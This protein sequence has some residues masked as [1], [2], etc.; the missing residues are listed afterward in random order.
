MGQQLAP[1]V[2]FLGPEEGDKNSAIAELR[3]AMAA[4][5]GDGL[6]EHTFYAFDTAI[7][8]VL[9]LLRNGSLFG[10][11]TIIR[12]RA[13]ESLKNKGDHEQLA[14]YVG[15]PSPDALLILETA[16]TRVADSLE[17]AVGKPNVRVF[18]EM[19]DNQKRGWLGGYFRRHKVSIEPDAVELILELVDNNTVDLQQEADRLI[20]WLGET[21]TVEDV[22]RYIYHVREESVFTL[23]DAIVA[24]DLDHALDIARA[25]L[26]TS[27]A[28][29]VLLGLSWQIDRLVAFQMIRAE[30]AADADLFT[31]VQRHLGGPPIRNR[32]AQESLRA[33]ARRY[34]YDACLRI[35]ALT[36][37]TDA[38]L[39]TVPS[40]LHGGLIETYLY[41]VIVRGGNWSPT[42]R[43][44]RA[45]PWEYPATAAARDLV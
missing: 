36:G 37:E 13:I 10:T 40:A 21:I 25:L 32:R 38:L 7:D 28:V 3:A 45:R 14:G 35:R 33:A 30:G 4:R 24:G 16:E 44:R 20:S 27:E 39:R 6:E 18:W 17:K 19:F 23:Y 9:A 2:A 1:V 43:M 31:L 34:P 12:Y 15:K 42:G 22:D 11:G 41:S 5:H 26:I 29:Q 8:H